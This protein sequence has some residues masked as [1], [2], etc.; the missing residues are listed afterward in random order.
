[1]VG[2][3]DSKKIGVVG[4]SDPVNGVMGAKI[5]VIINEQ[6]SVDYYEGEDVG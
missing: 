5:K 6:P 4:L 2:Y 3:P 1:M